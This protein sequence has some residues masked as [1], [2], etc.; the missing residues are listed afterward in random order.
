MTQP[1]GT[2]HIGLMVFQRIV[3]KSMGSWSGGFGNITM[4]TF[5]EKNVKANHIHFKI[6][7]MR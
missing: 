2:G 6:M 3:L 5:L 7:H 1:V 4:I